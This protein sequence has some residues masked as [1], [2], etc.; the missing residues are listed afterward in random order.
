MRVMSFNLLCGG[1][2][3]N[4][5]R[6]RRGIATEKI[7]ELKPDLLGVQEATPEWMRWLKAKL[8]DY[9]FVGVGRDDGKKKGEYSAVFYLKDKF[10]LL[11]SGTFWLS[12][13]P[14]KVSQGWDGVCKR[15]CSWALLQEKSSG[16]KLA[17]MNTHLDHKGFLARK[18]G[19]GLILEKARELDDYSL[20]VTG[21]FN[22]F[23][24]SEEY[25]WLMAGT[26]KDSKFLSPQ[27]EDKGT[28]HGFG[29]DGD[30][31]VIIDYVLVNDKF[32][33]Q[34]YRIVS[35]GVN[36]RAVS[37]HHPVCVDMDYN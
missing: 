12:E 18:N 22:L 15:I 25:E 35:E 3:E 26:L 37:D 6:K 4:T 10:D 31:K 9:A 27:T 21:D 1:E 14:D 5:V 2:G 11:D 16:K 19:I 7:L 32:K 23:E 28:F 33:P 17:H 20:V 29:E 36:G 24:G 8:S 13:T 34:T 30:M